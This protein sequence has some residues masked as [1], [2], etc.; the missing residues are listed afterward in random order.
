MMR[1]LDQN[2]SRVRQ[3]QNPTGPQSA[4]KIWRD[5]HIG[6]GNHAQWYSGL[7]DRELQVVDSS[8]DRRAF[9]VVH[10]RQDMRRCGHN[11]N[12]VGHERLRHAQGHRK[13]CSAIVDAWKDMA[14][15]IDHEGS[16]ARGQ[17]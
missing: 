4:D 16:P 5:V 11:G 13:I 6:T 12:A 17:E 3:R 2:V 14:M 1:R 7:V 10:A 8:A 15:Q 9:I